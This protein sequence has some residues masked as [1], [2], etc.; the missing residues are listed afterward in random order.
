MRWKM[1]N[2]VPVCFGARDDT[3]GTFNIRERGLIYT[4][5][6]VHKNGSLSCNTDTSPPSHW[7]CGHSIYRNKKLLTVITYPN[8]T[9]LPL[10]DYLRHERGC[11][12]RYY[13]YE[14]AGIGINS[15]ELVFNNLTTP[16][17][18]SNGQEFQIWDGQDL[19]DCSENNNGGQMC[20][21]VYALY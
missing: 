8:K 1:I 21:D 9:A 11:G 16:L 20:V 3:Y 14:I 17:A 2:N 13:S 6:L 4:F 18:V 12:L 10:A 7:G 5:K 15:P 19:T